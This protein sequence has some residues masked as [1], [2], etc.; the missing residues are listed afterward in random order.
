MG[1]LHRHV[2]QRTAKDSDGVHSEALVVAVVA[3]PGLA[4]DWLWYSTD[5]SATRFS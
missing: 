2:N 3:F 5:V 4:D 1:L